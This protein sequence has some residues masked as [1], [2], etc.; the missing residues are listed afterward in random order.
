MNSR[1]SLSLFF[2]VWQSSGNLVKGKLI[3]VNKNSLLY[4][5]ES[6]FLSLSRG[7]HFPIFTDKTISASLSR[8]YIFLLFN[9]SVLYFSLFANFFPI[10]SF[11]LHLLVTVKNAHRKTQPIASQSSHKNPIVSCTFGSCFREIKIPKQDPTSPY[12][13]SPHRIQHKDSDANR[14]GNCRVK[15]G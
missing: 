4:P 11:L 12:P 5:Q 7:K 3:P 10:P 13:V 14:R 2:N 9:L 8:H 15:E 6:V 1:N